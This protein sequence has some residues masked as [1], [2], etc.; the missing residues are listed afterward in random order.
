LVS[1]HQKNHQFASKLYSTVQEQPSHFSFS[2]NQ[3]LHDH[4]AY[5]YLFSVIVVHVKSNSISV[6]DKYHHK[7]VLLG[8]VGA[9]GSCHFEP[10]LTLIDAVDHFHHLKSNVIVC[11]LLLDHSY[12]SLKQRI[13]EAIP[14]L[15]VPLEMLE[16][17]E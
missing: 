2:A 7:K 15:R 1:S 10:C 17:E 12:E 3:L 9:D 14:G 16:V 13:D 11:K 8:L 4:F 6:H 5:K